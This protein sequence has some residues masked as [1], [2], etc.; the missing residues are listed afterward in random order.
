MFVP[1]FAVFAVCGFLLQRAKWRASKNAYVL[2]LFALSVLPMMFWWRTWLPML[3]TQKFP[4]LPANRQIQLIQQ[5]GEGYR[6]FADRTLVHGRQYILLDNIPSMYGLS[7]ISGYE[8]ELTRCFYGVITNI[9]PSHPHVRA[10]GA[11]G[12]KYLMYLRDVVPAGNLPVADT[13]AVTIYDNPWARP[14]A[15]ILYRSEMLPNDSLAL[16]RFFDD[17][18]THNSAL[19]TAGDGNPPLLNDSAA[20]TAATITS[21]ENNS[22]TISAKAE[23]PGYLVLSDTYYPGWKCWVDGSESQIYRANFAM[24]AVYMTPGE[25]HVVFRFEPQSFRIGSWISIASVGGVLTLFVG[26]PMFRRR[27]NNAV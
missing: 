20:W 23:R 14:R 22:V 26:I 15:T 24:R 2:T 19:F 18:D 4:L 5:H 3:D 16:R 1:F 8:S 13:G 7:D 27:R 9:S 12:V 25:H 10:L 11:L 6:I 21:A 17:S